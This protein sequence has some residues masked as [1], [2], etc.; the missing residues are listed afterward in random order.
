M[1]DEETVKKFALFGVILFTVAIV[2]I[3]FSFVTNTMVARIVATPAISAD[4]QAVTAF[5]SVHN[6][7]SRLDYIFFGLFMALAIACI[8]ASWYIVAYPVA[9]VIYFF[10]IAVSIIVSAVIS[11][12]F[13]TITS[14]A[15]FSA[16]MLTFPMTA[17]ILN[18]LPVYLT[19]ICFASIIVMFIKMRQGSDSPP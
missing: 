18:R 6:V 14:M 5:N 10:V 3:I 13:G 12:M 16:T 19:I 1:I 15:V 11:N 7:T 17:Q 9:V 4:P 2:F 8:F